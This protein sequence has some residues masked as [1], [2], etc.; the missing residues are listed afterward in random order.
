MG[1]MGNVA[2]SAVQIRSSGFIFRSGLLTCGA[3]AQVC[4]TLPPKVHSLFKQQ[5]LGRDI[6]TV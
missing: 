3:L 6:A 4:Q 1:L 5:A 2:G